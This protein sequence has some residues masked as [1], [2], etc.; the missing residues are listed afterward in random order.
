MNKTHFIT[1]DIFEQLQYEILSELM[2]N[3]EYVKIL[4]K[5]T[6]SV[7]DTKNSYRTI[8]NWSE[9]GI[10]HDSRPTADGWHKFSIID[11]AWLYIVN[12]LRKWNTRLNIIKTIKENVFETFFVTDP[13]INNL[14]IAFAASAYTTIYL[15]V[16]PNGTSFICDINSLNLNK[17]LN[18]LPNSYLKLNL[19]SLWSSF[20]KT[21]NTNTD[22]ETTISTNEAK[23][24]NEIRYNDTNEIN[25][26]KKDGK[27]NS[28]QL[29][30]TR[31]I[32]NS[33]LHEIYES[34][35]NGEIS[36][37]RRDGSSKIANIKITK[38]L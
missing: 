24:I 34:V 37:I 6:Y 2:E 21:A 38:K 11:M 3:P 32:T 36:V 14:M 31:E 9:K 13:T 12:E 26:R 25:I 10:I 28:M 18:N 33:G 19:N 27:P 20:I 8:N 15:I 17:G 35:P 7:K 22:I 23:I 30:K 4:Q 1:H 29:K 16:Y 5:T